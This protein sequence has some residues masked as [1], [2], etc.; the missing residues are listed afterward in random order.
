VRDSEGRLILAFEDLTLYAG[1]LIQVT[2]IRADPETGHLVV[3]FGEGGIRPQSWGITVQPSPLV[4]NAED[5]GR[6]A[7]LIRAIS[8][9]LASGQ[10]DTTIRFLNLICARA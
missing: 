7:G 6:T 4:I 3:S 5:S 10:T 9:S 1:S 2:G 8:N